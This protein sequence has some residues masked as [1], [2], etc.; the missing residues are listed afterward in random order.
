MPNYKI[1]GLWG[2]E[3]GP[4]A[5][6]YVR[7]PNGKLVLAVLD[8]WTKEYG[9][10][11]EIATIRE[12][13]AT[14]PSL[15]VSGDPGYYPDL[16]AI[17]D[18]DLIAPEVVAEAKAAQKEADDELRRNA[19]T[20]F[21]TRNALEFRSEVL[22]R[23]ATGGDRSHCERYARVTDEFEDPTWVC[24][25]NLCYYYDP[26]NYYRKVDA[27]AHVHMPGIM[28]GTDEEI[29]CDIARILEEEYREYEEEEVLG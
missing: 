11:E 5:H 9:Y 25:T 16:G 29:D 27:I 17:P 13:L 19:L 4:W 6:A 15:L 23:T 20:G 8:E 24:E 18:A 1:E 10:D 12:I 3:S 21:D 7:L 28:W 22:Q 14:A 2:F 26:D